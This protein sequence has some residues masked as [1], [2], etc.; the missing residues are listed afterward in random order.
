[1]GLKAGIRHNQNK[2]SKVILQHYCH[3]TTLYLHLGSN[4]PQNLLS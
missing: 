1:M 4:T 3:F 2:M